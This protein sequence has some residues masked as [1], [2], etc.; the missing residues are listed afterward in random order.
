MFCGHNSYNIVHVTVY[1]DLANVNLFAYLNSIA[2][3]SI[4]IQ[5]SVLKVKLMKIRGKSTV[6]DEI[7]TESSRSSNASE[8]FIKALSESNKCMHRLIQVHV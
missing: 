5:I 7:T 3:R 4:P 2:S 1:I 6:S 8:G